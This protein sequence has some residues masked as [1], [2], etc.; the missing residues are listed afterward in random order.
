MLNLLLNALSSFPHLEMLK[1]TFPARGS[2]KFVRGAEFSQPQDRGFINPM[3][4]VLEGDL[5]CL[6]SVD[7]ILLWNWREETRA[8]VII[9]YPH[10]IVCLHRVFWLHRESDT[11]LL[12]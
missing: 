1:L 6:Y 3:P 2:P 5:V 9:E 12:W 4:P 11:C 7:E 8:F 10:N